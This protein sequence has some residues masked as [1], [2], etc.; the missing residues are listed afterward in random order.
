MKAQSATATWAVRL[1][2]VALALLAIGPLL[3]HLGVTSPM[4][5][6]AVFQL[7]LLLGLVTLVV[8]VIGV[9]RTGPSSGREGR[10]Q[11]VTGLVLGA[12]VL[13]VVGF[14]ARDGA[15]VPAI[16]DIT[17]DLADPPAFV[18]A[19]NLEANRGR[20]MSYPGEEFAA[21]QRG[22][23][24]DLAPIPHPGSPAQAY[25]DVRAAVTVLG[26]EVIL[27]DAEARRIEANETTRIVRFVDDVV[28]RVRASDGGGSVIDVRSKS[29]DG[30]GDLGAN[31]KRIRALR[32]TLASR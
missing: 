17:T 7:G 27:E 28:V 24:T 14:S 1:G 31:A 3:T 22:A 19:N 11:A 9:L 23:Y 30:R 15:G 8:S 25:S 4:Q 18:V 6:F 2:G 5:G 13:A 21:Q 20:D 29:R 32:D 16:N 12:A 10:S 26:W